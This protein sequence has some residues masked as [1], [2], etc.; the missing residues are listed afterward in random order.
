MKAVRD[1]WLH[2][3]A[4][5][6]FERSKLH[7]EC[8]AASRFHFE[9]PKFYFEA[10]RSILKKNFESPELHPEAIE[11]FKGP[12]LL[13]SSLEQNF[14]RFEAAGYSLAEF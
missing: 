14:E 7:P 6:R 4:E 5:K 8:Q 10:D 1:L 3:K 12:R 11:H 2:S 13:G 9:G